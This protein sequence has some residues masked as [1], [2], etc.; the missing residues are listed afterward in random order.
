MFFLYFNP[1]HNLRVEILSG[2]TSTGAWS[3]PDVDPLWIEERNPSLYKPR[4]TCKC[5]LENGTD[6][7]ESLTFVQF[8]MWAQRFDKC[9]KDM[10]LA[11]IFFVIFPKVI[12]CDRLEGVSSLN[13]CATDLKPLSAFYRFHQIRSCFFQPHAYCVRKSRDAQL[14]VR[15]DSKDTAKSLNCNLQQ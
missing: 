14:F 13:E 2:V 1:S 12:E 11:R 15:S 6:V 3:G 5:N 10:F 8:L 4:A 9:T 7:V